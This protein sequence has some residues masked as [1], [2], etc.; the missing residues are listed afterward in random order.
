MYAHVLVPV[1]RLG[2]AKTRLAEALSPEER[3]ELMRELLAHVLDAVQQAKVGPVTVV[4]SEPLPLNGV[5]R[6]DDQDLPWNDALAT[7]M[8]MVVREPVVAVV[9]ADL[10]L[11]SP[12]DVRTLVAF[13]PQRGVAIARA[14]DG[15]TNAIAMR[16]P[17]ILATCFG[18][19]ESAALHERTAW[20]V[21]ADAH[22]VDLPGLAFD[23]D[24]PEDL[25]AWR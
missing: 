3:A 1:K 10:P 2:D 18:E 11:L 24:T 8:R 23:I 25:R 4:S 20:T 7:A 21:G 22:I 16:P 6:F 19:R 15:G 13:A 17:G 9:S 5:P 14:T 12:D